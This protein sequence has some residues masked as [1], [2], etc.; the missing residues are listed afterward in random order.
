MLLL[1]VS[2]AT[3]QESSLRQPPKILHVY[4]WKDLSAQFTNSQIISMDGISV[5]KIENTNDRSL[6]VLLLTITNSSLIQ[7]A[8]TIEWEMKCENVLLSRGYILPPQIFFTSLESEL[9]G[10]GWGN[11][12][13]YP[14]VCFFEKFPPQAAGGDNITNYQGDY[15]NGTQNWDKYYFSLRRAPYDNQTRS[16]ELKLEIF[17]PS[18]GTVYLRPIKLLGI[19][20]NWWSEKEAPWIGAIGGPIIGCLGGLLGWLSGKGKARR[21]VLTVW[22]FCIVAGILFLT[23]LF[24]ALATGQPEYVSM[25]L[26]VFGIVT[27]TVFGAIFPTAKRRYDELEIRRM[28]SVDV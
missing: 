27:T 21:L 1:L 7:K 28:T 3:A 20:S 4:D 18:S 5:L 22:K 6:K 16:D 12:T 2:S 23:A 26:F 11:F 17:L 24:V 10:R 19:A 9:L 14:N 25:P 8:N 13:N 15:F